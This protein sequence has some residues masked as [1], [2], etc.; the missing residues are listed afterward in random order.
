VK[1]LGAARFDA[2]IARVRE[3]LRLAE[4]AALAEQAGFRTQRRS[5]LNGPWSGGDVLVLDTLGELPLL[6]PLAS[7]VFVGG[8][9]VP[10]GGHNVLEAAVAARPVIVGPHMENFQEIAEEFRA[11]GALVTVASAVDLAQEVA[12]LLED[13]ARRAELG[14]RGRAIVDRN[15]GAL[16]RTVAALAGLVA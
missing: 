16:E 12:S 14:R 2:A 3:R 15:R 8:S 4:A 13:P 7:V 5:G 6:Y 10:A 1:P 11:E 9:L